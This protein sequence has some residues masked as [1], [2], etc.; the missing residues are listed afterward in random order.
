M[1]FAPN[2]STKSV[3]RVCVLTICGLSQTL[4]TRPVLKVVFFNNIKYLDLFLKRVKNMIAR[5]SF[6]TLYL[7][8]YTYF[9]Y[10]EYI[11]TPC[12][13]SQQNI[14]IKH[15]IYNMHKYICMYIVCT[16][17]TFNYSNRYLSFLSSDSNI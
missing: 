4:R 8:I 11:I 6:D 10:S 17:Q 16:Q 1:L 14:H 9:L 3:F 15:R 7:Y 2:L 5:K 12:S 13:A